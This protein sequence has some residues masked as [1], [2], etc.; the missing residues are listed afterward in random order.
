MAKKANNTSGEVE[1]EAHFMSREEFDD[2]ASEVQK[3]WMFFF[4]DKHN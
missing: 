4:K 3:S 1:G 2:F